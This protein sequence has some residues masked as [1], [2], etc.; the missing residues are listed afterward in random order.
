MIFIEVSRASRNSVKAKEITS[1]AGESSVFTL[2]TAPLH[3]NKLTFVLVVVWQAWA[4]Y[5]YTLQHHC[6]RSFTFCGFA[7]V[8]DI[9]AL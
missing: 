1:C 5:D 4:I 7:F 3:A 2:F 9:T 6:P 8:W